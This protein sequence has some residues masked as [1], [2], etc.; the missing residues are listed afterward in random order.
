[1]SAPNLGLLNNTFHPQVG[2]L[3]QVGLAAAAYSLRKLRQQ[4]NG[5]AIRVRR[6]SDNAETDIGFA[7]NTDGIDTV[8]LL[9]FT[10]ANSGFVTTWYDQSG[11]GRNAAQATAVNQPR[12]VDAGVVETD[13]GRPTVRYPTAGV[14]LATTVTSAGW[15]DAPS[16][17]IVSVARCTNTATARHIVGNRGGAGRFIR[18]QGGGASYQ[19]INTGAL[20]MTVSGTTTNQNVVTYRYDGTTISGWVNGGSATSAAAGYFSDPTATVS[21]GGSGGGSADWIGTISEIVVFASAISTTGRQTL[22]RNQGSYYS[23]GVS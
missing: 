12:I 2:V 6:S 5:P 16:A 23:I 15:F 20:A 1:M 14:G 4:Y 7:T 18:A 17:S 8:A 9:A 3:D 13:G 10:G 11:N 19:L 21:I 22:E